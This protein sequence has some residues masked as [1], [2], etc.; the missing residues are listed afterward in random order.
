MESSFTNNLTNQKIIENCM[1]SP[2]ELK[3]LYYLQ[4][5]E[6]TKH[7]LQCKIRDVDI[8]QDMLKKMSAKIKKEPHYNYVKRYSSVQHSLKIVNK[9]IE[10]RF[11]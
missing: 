2:D 6:K 5:Y 7:E 4:S 9:T 11:D 1:F 10:I 8:T 3:H